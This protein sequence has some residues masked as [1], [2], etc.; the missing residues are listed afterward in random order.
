MPTQQVKFRGVKATPKAL[1]KGLIETSKMLRDNPAIIIPQ[2]SGEKCSKCRF[3]KVQRKIEKVSNFKDDPEKL[4][5]LAKRGD[6]LVR[7]YA[8]AISLAA[9]GKIPYLTAAQLPV[10]EV[11]FA[12]RGKVDRE[13]LIGIQHFDDPDLR[14]LAY[15]DI[16]KKRDLH[17]Y[18]TDERLFCSEGGAKV[19]EK[20]VTE[21]LEQSE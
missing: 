12:V 2:C 21:M 6:Q 5:K 17:I 20:Y 14:L 16:A 1:E 4:N 13:K 3:D 18:S 9:S 7:A 10:G 8:A 15:F 19:P 11:S